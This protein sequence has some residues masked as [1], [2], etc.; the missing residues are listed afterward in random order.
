LGPYE[1]WIA[2][3]RNRVALSMFWRLPPDLAEAVIREF[4]AM[5]NSQFYEA[6]IAILTGPGWPLH[7]QLLAG[8]TDS[9]VRQRAEFAKELYS[10]GYDVAVPGI[11]PPHERRPW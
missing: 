1:G 3:R 9:D 2:D 7:D 8:L 4:A 5:V 10:A 11:A 6:A